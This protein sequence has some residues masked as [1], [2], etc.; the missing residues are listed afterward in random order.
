MLPVETL[1]AVGLEKAFVLTLN[2]SSFHVTRHSD[3]H[4]GLPKR[5]E[6]VGPNAEHLAMLLQ[7]SVSKKQIFY[8]TFYE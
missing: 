7:V 1:N 6:L 2:L 5:T 4:T 3:R 8:H